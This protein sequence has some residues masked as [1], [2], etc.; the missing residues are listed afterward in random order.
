M[1]YKAIPFL[2]LIAGHASAQTPGT[3]AVSEIEISSADMAGLA[4]SATEYA[5]SLSTA[6][7][8]INEED[9][10]EAEEGEGSGEDIF[11]DTTTIEP[12]MPVNMGGNGRLTVTRKDT[13]EKI[14]INYRMKDGGYDLAELAKFNHITR[15]S[16]TGAEKTMAIKLVELLDAVEDHFGKKGILL[17]S[18]FRS[19]KLNRLVPGAAEHSLHMLGWAADIRIPGYSSTAVKKYALKLGVGGVG[20]YPSMGFTHLDVGKVRYWAVKRHVR[21]RRPHRAAPSR[22]KGKAARPAGKKSGARSPGRKK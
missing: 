22:G 19:L 7:P 18:G 4:V 20:Y 3:A 6:V 14:T 5:A 10:T 17:M 2:L 8:E 1:T 13:G 11:V 21:A 16:L 12:P 15:C 9:V